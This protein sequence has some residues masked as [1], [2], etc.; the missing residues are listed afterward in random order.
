MEPNRILVK[1]YVRKF[2]LVGINV[3]NYVI[4]MNANVVS[5]QMFYANVE[6]K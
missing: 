6:N 1:I 5:Q 4:M 3:Q 2:Y